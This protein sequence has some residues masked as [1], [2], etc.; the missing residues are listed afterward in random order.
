M[1]RIAVVFLVAVL[2][3]GCSEANPMDKAISLRQRILNAGG[4]SFDATVTADYG[5]ILQSFSL[6]CLVDE[7]GKLTFEVL[8]PE[9]IS[10]ITGTMSAEGG[11]LTF[12]S[13]VLAFDPLAEGQVAPVTAPWLLVH[14]LRGG[15]IRACGEESGGTR[16]TIDDSYEEDT[17]QIDIWL[18][19][20]D[21]PKEA[22]ILWHGRRILS[23]VI[24]NFDL[25]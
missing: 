25:L 8:S 22:E 13:Q 18:D 7:S 12:D 9:S 20:K 5:D 15:Y 6:R 11:S 16:L 21:A 1:K 14:T 10:G 17:L 3:F 23:L 2:L 19:E 4:I 24:E